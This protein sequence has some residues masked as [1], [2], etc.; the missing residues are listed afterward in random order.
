MQDGSSGEN[1]TVRDWARTIRNVEGTGDYFQA[2]EVARKA[3]AAFPDDEQLK[4]MAVRALARSGAAER[5]L[6]LYDQYGL[7][8]TADL[9]IQMLRAGLVKDLGLRART[10]E[11]WPNRSTSRSPNNL[12]TNMN[13]TTAM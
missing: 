1:Q 13:P 12:P 8:N 6:E 10:T 7:K 3:I 11:R 9:D 5:A 4:Y 2:F